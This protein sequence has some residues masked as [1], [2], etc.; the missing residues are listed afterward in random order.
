[1]P[2]SSLWSCISAELLRQTLYFSSEI[3]LSKLKIPPKKVVQ[4]ID[5]FK[6][7]PEKIK[8]LLCGMAASTYSAPVVLFGAGYI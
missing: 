8:S 2:C 5:A 6:I 3:M 7:K 1:M 4:R